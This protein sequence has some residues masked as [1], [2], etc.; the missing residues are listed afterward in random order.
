MRGLALL[1]AADAVAVWWLPMPAF[2]QSVVLVFLALL[3]LALR[4]A[5][6]RLDRVQKTVTGPAGNGH[7]IQVNGGPEAEE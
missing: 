2:A 7:A 6:G 4:S 1:M 5:L 3:L